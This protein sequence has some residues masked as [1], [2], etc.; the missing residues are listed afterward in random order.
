MLRKYF[1]LYLQGTVDV[2]SNFSKNLVTIYRASRNN[3]RSHRCENLKPRFSSYQTSVCVDVIRLSPPTNSHCTENT[4]RY[5]G[6]K[7]IY[8]FGNHIYIDYVLAEKWFIFEVFLKYGGSSWHTQDGNVYSGRGHE[9]YSQWR[10]TRYGVEAQDR[11]YNGRI[12]NKCYFRA[13]PS[14]CFIFFRPE[15]SDR[16]AA[17]LEDLEPACPASSGRDILINNASKLEGN[18]KVIHGMETCGGMEW[19]CFATS[20]PWRW[21][22][23]NLAQAT[24]R[25]IRPIGCSKVRVFPVW[26]VDENSLAT[27]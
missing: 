11:H 9:R 3:L 16:T 22:R 14:V 2:R 21:V 15:H 23:H 7:F 25:M 8:T 20:W 18:G 26:G 5:F 1:V 12:A 19:S 6:R 13:G 10:R 4:A 17:S 27:F 24:L